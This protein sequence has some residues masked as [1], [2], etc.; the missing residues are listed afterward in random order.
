MKAINR[1]LLLLVAV[2]LVFTACPNPAGDDDDDGDKGGGGN[3]TG[4]VSF[5]SFSPP[6]IYVDNN[7]G[8]RLVAFKG[9]LN[10]NNL[11]SGIPAYQLNHG[12]KKVSL[13]TATGAFPLVLIK[14]ADYNANK[15]NLASVT[16][17]AK[18]FAFYNHTATNNNHFQISAKVGGDARLLVSNPTPYNVEIRKDGITGD[19]LG[20]V[21]PNMTSGNII[22]LQPEVYDIYPVFKFYIPGQNNDELYTVV[23]KYAAVTL[24]GRPYMET[25]TFAETVLERSF[26]VNKIYD[27]G[28]FH[29]SSGGVYFRIT[30]NSGVDVRIE[31]GGVPKITS[32]GQPTVITGRSEVFTI[33]ISP[34]PDKTYPDSQSIGQI[35]IGSTQNML[36]IPAQV[37]RLDYM[38]EIVVNGNDNSTL[39]LGTV[40]EKEKIDLDALLG[41]N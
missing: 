10:P 22:Y 41:L 37:Y 19:I 25:I 3:N 31:Q 33:N 23:P 27:P 8:E 4:A 14:E 16:P 17:F 1:F 20:Y 40:E 15:N 32:I 12:L 35:K 26:N 9:D 18:I 34:N 7:T 30:N 11:I 39:T 21:A 29:W 24:E 2:A 13:F 5:E 36:T 28:S 38:Y 6:S